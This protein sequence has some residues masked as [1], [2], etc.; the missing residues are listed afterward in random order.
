M[1]VLTRSGE[2]F[3]FCRFYKGEA[4]LQAVSGAVTVAIVLS[5]ARA[6]S[7]CLRRLLV[8]SSLV[9]TPA[10]GPVPPLILVAPLPRTSS[11]IFLLFFYPSSSSIPPFLLSLVFAS[12]R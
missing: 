8:S 4:F 9:Y 12:P 10:F 1:G 3:H 11:S 5:P 7:C 2:C 6:L